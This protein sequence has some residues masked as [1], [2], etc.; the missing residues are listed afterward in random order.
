MFGKQDGNDSILYNFPVTADGFHSLWLI[1]SVT[2]FKLLIPWARHM[3]VR[4]GYDA[5]NRLAVEIQG[6]S[7]K[8]FVNGIQV[9]NVQ[10][11][12]P[13]TGFIGFTV[14]TP[15]MEVVFTNVRVIELLKP[16]LTSRAQQP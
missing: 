7:I 16:E 9:G 8:T 2:D 14:A 10:A 3:S 5:L 13:V 6:R 15:G 4:T 1:S 12:A 11:Q